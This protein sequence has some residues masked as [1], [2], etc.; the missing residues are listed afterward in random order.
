MAILYFL[1]DEHQ[2]ALPMTEQSDTFWGLVKSLSLKQRGSEALGSSD[3][4]MWFSLGLGPLLCQSDSFARACDSTLSD[5]LQILWNI[6]MATKIARV[7]WPHWQL[8]WIQ[9]AQQG[10][11]SGPGTRDNFLKSLSTWWDGGWALGCLA[12]FTPYCFFFSPALLTSCWFGK[13][14]EISSIMP[15]SA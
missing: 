9:T 8:Y 5:S 7:H 2:D 4:G 14:P 1:T 10:T 11:S 15:F 3:E 6:V 12:S 13:V